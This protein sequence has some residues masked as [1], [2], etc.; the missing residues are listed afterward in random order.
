[1]SRETNLNQV[2]AE[3]VAIEQQASAERG[4]DEVLAAPNPGV[5]VLPSEGP[6]NFPLGLSGSLTKLTTGEDYLV[7]GANIT[8]A[9][10]SNGSIT[11]SSVAGGPGGADTEVQFNDGGTAFSGSSSFTFNKTTNTLRV[12][13]LSG[14][15][16]KLANG[17]DYLRGGTGILLVTGTNGSVTITST[18][19]NETSWASYTPTITAT[20]AAPTLPTAH[21]IYGKYVVQGKMMTL[22]FSLSYEA[23]AGASAGSGTYRISMPPGFSANLTS[24]TAPKYSNGS[25]IGTA[26]LLADVAGTGG[27]WSVI[28]DTTTTLVLVGQD[29]SSS[30]Q[31]AAWGSSN[32]YIG[33]TENLRVS[34]IATIP[35]V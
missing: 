35:V 2:E 9:T 25:H 11:I 12:T 14:S 24:G 20:T 8:L 17:T 19:T 31:P 26:A 23:S 13:N 29:P 6:A 5:I 32:F 7:A 33:Q 27:G 15:L 1:M 16:T 3:R 30:A 28:T 4:P 18:A 34:F 10:A 22:M 21:N